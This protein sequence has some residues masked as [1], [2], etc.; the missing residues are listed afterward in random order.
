MTEWSLFLARN[1][2]E[3]CAATTPAPVLAEML[4]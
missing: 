4:A 2:L 1:G 3:P